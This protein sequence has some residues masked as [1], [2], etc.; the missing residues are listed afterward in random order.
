[1]RG[2]LKVVN[3]AL[4]APLLIFA[5][6]KDTLTAATDHHGIADR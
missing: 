3:F 4:K 6:G 5:G 2:I 1:M